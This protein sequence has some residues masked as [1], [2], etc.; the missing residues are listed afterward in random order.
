MRE[1]KD[2]PNGVFTCEE[3]RG[4]TVLVASWVLWNGSVSNRTRPRLV[5][6]V[7][8]CGYHNTCIHNTHITCLLHT[9][10]IV[11]THHVFITH[12]SRVHTP[13]VHPNAHA[14]VESS[15]AEGDAVLLHEVD[16]VALAHADGFERVGV[17]QLRLRGALWTR[18]QHHGGDT[19]HALRI[20]QAAM[21]RV[22]QMCVL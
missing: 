5:F 21:S 13:R 16:A 15:V 22:I 11:T 6:T 18:L 1:S 17:E 12:T 7:R 9:H 10:Q 20:L 4:T 8:S 2:A 14:P 3:N 19:F